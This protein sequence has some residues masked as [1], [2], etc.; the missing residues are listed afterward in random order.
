MSVRGLS[1]DV[2]ENWSQGVITALLADRLPDG[3]AFV[4]KNTQFRY[5][6]PNNTVFG[7]RSGCSVQN[8]TV[9]AAPASSQHFLP[10]SSGSAFHL[11]VLSNG[12]VGSMTTGTYSEIAAAGSVTRPDDFISWQNF[13]DFAFFV[14]GTDLLKTD[15]SDTFSFGIEQPASGDWS[16]SAGGSGGVLPVDTYDIAIG[17]MNSDSGHIGPTSDIKTVTTTAAQKITVNLPNNTTID[18]PQVDYVRIYIR[19]RS[20]RT[21]LLLVAA[22]TSPAITSGLG[23]AVNTSPVVIDSSSAQLTA[24]TVLAPDVNDNYPPPADTKFIIAHKGRMFA[25]TDRELFWSEIEEPENFNTADNAITVGEDDGETA[26]GLGL[27][28]EVLVVFKRNAIYALEGD[29]P[30]T[31]QLR[32]IDNT[33][34]CV[35][36][37]S[38]VYNNNRMFWL[39]LR[40]PQM[41]PIGASLI[42]ITSQLIS[43]QFDEAHID[44]NDLLSAVGIS[45]PVEEYVGFAVQPSSESANTIIIPFHSKLERWMATEWR[46]V[47]VRSACTIV[48]SNGRQFPMIADN[49]GYIY[50]LGIETADGL[51]AG[52]AGTGTVTSSGSATL[53]N[54][55]AAWTTNALAGRYVY[56]WGTANGVRQAQRRRIVSNT[57]TQLTVSDAW[58]T[59][60]S[61]GDHYSVGGILLD[62]RTGFRN[63]GGPFYR[64]RIEFGFLTLGVSD[65]GNDVE[66]EFFRDLNDA[67]AINSRTLGIGAASLWDTAVFDV[68]VF[69]EAG[70]K[71]F[72]IPIR[73]VGYNWQTRISHMSGGDQ[74]Y[75]HRIAV[76]WLTKTKKTSRSVN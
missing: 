59:N 6:G 55:S 2:V 66:V 17:Y 21:E 1:E 38:I 12:A 56:T 49:T 72:R 33:V 40:G 19:P 47:D 22:G 68:D 15:G 60:P 3:A 39:S 73:S 44:P 43:P 74:L 67:D 24:F 4:A 26:I 76:Q 7:T 29:D 14:N 58:D 31:W 41:W 32:L 62:F 45:S 16:I 48:D 34:G 51:P 37:A 65:V 50:K 30:Q 75:I 10:L 69:T 18:D 5:V 25:L 9:L 20:L 42:D 23:W 70:T 53:T 35:S 54:L 63:G 28:G 57:A 64:K 52:Q 61:L 27:L 11:L 8:S 13:D 71:T 36:P 46:I